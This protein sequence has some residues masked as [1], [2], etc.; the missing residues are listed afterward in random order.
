MKDKK[1]KLVVI[2]ALFMGAG[3]LALSILNWNKTNQNNELNEQ[4]KNDLKSII[5][6]Q[7]KTNKFVETQIDDIRNEVSKWY[8]YCERMENER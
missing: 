8:K 1:E 2:S 6:Y 7:E 4:I 3:G 5:K